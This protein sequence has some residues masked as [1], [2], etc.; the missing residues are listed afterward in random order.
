MTYEETLQFL[1]HNPW[2]F[3]FVDPMPG[4]KN[5]R[6][7]G[8]DIGGFNC[9]DYPENVQKT[10]FYERRKRIDEIG[11][12]INLVQI[13]FGWVGVDEYDYR[14]VD[15]MLDQV[16]KDYPDRYFIPRFHMDAPFEW[17]RQHPEELCVLWKGPTDPE[18]IK[19]LVGTEYQINIASSVRKE[20]IGRQS[21][22]SK[23]WQED[24]VKALRRFVEHLENSP[25][26]KQIIGY[27][28]LFGECGENLWW[29]FYPVTEEHRGDFGI[30]HR[31]MFYEWAV[32]RYGSLEN[33]RKAWNMQGLT[34]ENIPIPTPEETWSCHLKNW[35]ETKTLRSLLL[36]DDQ[37][38]VDWNLFH[39]EVTFDAIELFARTIKEMTGKVTGVFYGYTL[40]PS[41]GYCGQI[42]TD[43]AMASP[44]LDF[45]SAPKS[46]AYCLGGDPGE[47]QGP[48]QSF[49]RK[50]LWI[51][52]NDMRSSNLLKTRP[53]D[54]YAPKT[55]SD[56]ITCYWRELFRALTGK[57]GFWW[58]DINGLADDWYTD[59]T[60]IAMFKH[61][62]DFF[63]KWS[64]VPRKS[65]TE[66]L[67]IEDDD[68]NGHMTTRW[69]I[70]EGLRRKLNREL[71]LCGAPVDRYR[72]SDLLELDLSQYKFIVFQHAFVMP[73]EKW[74]KILSRIRPDAHI[75]WNYAAGLLDPSYNPAN[76]K[77]VTGFN[78]M[79]TPDRMAHSD[80]YRHIYHHGPGIIRD[81]YPH[82]AIIPE[83][84]QEVLQTT[85]DQYIMTARIDRGQGK[86]IYAADITLRTPLLR[87]LMEDAGV[88]FYAPQYCSVQADEKLIGYFPRYDVMIEHNFEGE[89][90]NVITGE[91]VSGKAKIPVREKSF[92][93]FEKLS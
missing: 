12:M 65:V 1:L 38:Q 66:V 34:K 18:E 44:W 81:D 73:K 24:A 56:S 90:R 87:K 62:A 4:C 19:D 31:K 43:R 89:W 7:R 17:C 92:A 74:E 42:L 60:L 15:Y 8:T 36:A 10:D 35:R 82:L 45:Y 80:I 54:T 39:S 20:K 72:I 53:N 50:K 47:S 9:G 83:E 11:A 14:N 30:T 85:P 40:E 91:I 5:V 2:N 76:Q 33:L 26:A 25:Y 67:W 77:A 63:K 79:E 84:G 57:F 49:S 55:L 52:E 93:I 64:P 6:D 27:M 32:K 70:Q 28:P 46:Y 13:P 23:L 29:G 51:E 21:F 41:A 59:E 71:R 68:S 48:G 58:M 88:N 86:N 22:S 69:S 78:T 37:R 61:Q 3:Y 16:L 75:L